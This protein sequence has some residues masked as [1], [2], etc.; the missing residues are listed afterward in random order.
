MTRGFKMAGDNN[1]N[2]GEVIDNKF[3]IGTFNVRGI[4][5]NKKRTAIFRS[6]KKEK[7]DKNS[8]E[9]E[10]DTNRAGATLGLQKNNEADETLNLD[11]KEE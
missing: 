10:N 11:K 9:Y 4:R 5:N 6:L 1:W 2:K 7:Y 8:K 3:K